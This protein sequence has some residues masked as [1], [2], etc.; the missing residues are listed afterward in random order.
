MQT[1]L[2]VEWVLEDVRANRAKQGLLQFVENGQVN[3]LVAFSL[4]R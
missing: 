1:L 4:I 2:D 3:D